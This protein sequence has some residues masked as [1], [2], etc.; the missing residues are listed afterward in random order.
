MFLQL[1]AEV[2]DALADAL[3]T[4]DLP[5]EDLGI[6]EPPEDVDAVLASSVAFRLAGEVGTAPPNVASDIADAIAAD[7]L[8]Y[9]SDVTTQGPYVN[10]LPSEAYFAETLQSVTESGFGRLPD[11]DTSVVVEHTSANPTGPVHVGRA[12]NPIIGDAVAR[13]LD[14]AGYDVDRH[15]YV[16]DAGRQIAVFTW[17]YETFD[18]DDLPEPERESPEY[19]M[20]RYYR[21]G[22]TILEDGDPDE[23]EAAE[24]EVQSI[25]Q[26]LEDGDEETYERVAEVVDTVLG[27]MQNTLGRLPA[28][29]DEFVK[30]TKFMRNGDTDDLVDRLKGLD[31][32]VYE[33]DAWQLD[34]PDFEKNLVF[35][36]SDGT[37][38]YTTRDLA[39]HEWKF[40]T[41]DRAVTVLGED[42]KL[43]ADQLAAAL[44]LLDNDTDQ[45]RQVFYSWVN[46]PEGGMSTREGTGIDLDDL[47]D[48][49]ID[50]AREEVESRLDDRTRG[51]LDEDDIDRIARQVGIGA[52]RYDIVSKQPTKGITFEWDR[53]LDFEAQS[54]PYV[55]YVHARC[56]GI[57][58]DVETDIPDEPDLDPLSEPEER[59]LLRELARFPAVIEAAADDLTPHT[60]ATYTRDLAE[61]FNAFYR[62]CPVL[63][64]DPETRAARLALVD[65][66]RTTI[67]NAL[68]ALGVEAPT[69]M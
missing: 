51:D 53:A 22:N 25:L 49:A 60:V 50:R 64:A 47:L 26:G 23:V 29:F 48:E 24:A 62:E 19:E 37:S 57:L 2:E 20:V 1:R 31:C 46:L 54:A 6:E 66:T 4:L 12:R 11:R 39:H 58:G 55:Q 3:T 13:V 42:H 15:Y 35:L 59:D 56:C 34:L 36:R 43:Q 63:D 27:G 69:S 68:D 32:A 40:D 33:E 45:L 44:E 9:V 52:V 30:E 17:A 61:T 65:G 67:A 8:T 21:K 28:E 41:Y 5:A 10:F 7:D 38:L 16:N 14:Y 18:E